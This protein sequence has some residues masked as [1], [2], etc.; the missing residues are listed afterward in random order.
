MKKDIRDFIIFYK[1]WYSKDFCDETVNQLKGASY[2]KHT[3][4]SP[5]SKCETT[6]GD[7][8]YLINERIPNDMIIF[9]DIPNI[10]NRYIFEDMGFEWAKHWEGYTFPKFNRYEIETSMKEHCDHISTIFDGT[11]KG[12]P[13]LSILGCLNDDYDIEFV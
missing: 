1:K 5:I 3:F 11:R 4:Y 13:M 8:C 12:L 9:N 10:I 2:E 6:V 7:D